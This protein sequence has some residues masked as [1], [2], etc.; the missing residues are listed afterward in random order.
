MQTIIIVVLASFATLRVIDSSLP[1]FRAR[2]IEMLTPDLLKN[3]DAD[4]KWRLLGQWQLKHINIVHFPVEKGQQHT[5]YLSVGHV[6]HTQQENDI[7]L[8][9]VS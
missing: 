2:S 3:Y 4:L 1:C 8:D 9:C 6:P 5:I 7:V